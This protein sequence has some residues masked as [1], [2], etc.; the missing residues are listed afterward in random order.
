LD[1]G[2]IAEDIEPP[3][4]SPNGEDLQMQ[5]LLFRYPNKAEREASYARENQ[6]PVLCLITPPPLS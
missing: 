1:I 5:V 6:I 4:H 2:T 3:T